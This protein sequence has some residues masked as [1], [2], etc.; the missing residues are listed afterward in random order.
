MMKMEPGFIKSHFVQEVREL[1]QLARQKAYRAVHFIMVETY[2]Q[3]GRRIVEEEQ[4]GKERADM[5][6]SSSGNCPGR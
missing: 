2:W 1:L 6:F 5:G 3:V 4:Q